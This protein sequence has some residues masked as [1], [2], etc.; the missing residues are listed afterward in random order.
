[1]KIGLISVEYPPHYGGGISTYTDNLSRFLSKAGH[2][3]HVISNAW[4]DYGDAKACDA[5]RAPLPAH[6][7]IHRIDAFHKN[8]SLRPAF[9]QSLA[10]SVVREW[11]VAMFWSILVADKLEEIHRQFSLDI[12][13]FPESSAHG[14]VTL[15]RRAAG[16][17]I[18]VPITV[19]LHGPMQIVNAY[20]YLSRQRREYHRM[21]SMEEY[22]IRHADLLSSPSRWLAE[23]VTGQKELKQ[24]AHRCTVIP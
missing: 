9:R 1:M 14:Y 8:F 2:E 23:R 5:A 12:V 18:D 15:G 21:A 6:L 20:N 19:T 17:G 13:E 22:C 16:V 7:H 24:Q 10:S 11:G 4:V 3:V